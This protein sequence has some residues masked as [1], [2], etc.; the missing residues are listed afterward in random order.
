[1]HL[2][3]VLALVSAL[4]GLLVGLTGVGGGAL[5]TPVLVMVFGV[6]PSAA[7]A[8]DLVAAL[9]MKPAGVL[10][11]WRRGGV[12]LPLVRYLCYGS[13]PGALAGTWCAHLVVHTTHG[14]HLLRLTLGLALVTG[15]GSMLWRA[16]VG[17][18]DASGEVVTRRVATVVVGVV[19][20]FM[21]GL[22]SVGAGS[23]VV[24]LLMLLYPTLEN[25]QIA[26]T[27]LAQSIPLTASAALGAI[28]FSRVDWSL[29]ASILTGALP[30][31]VVGSWWSRVAPVRAW[32]LAIAWVVL[33]SGLRY[34]G[35]T[36]VSV[37]AFTALAILAWALVRRRRRVALVAEAIEDVVTLLPS[38]L[39]GDA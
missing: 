16:R 5:M 31:V 20:G 17:D 33:L 9:L 27:D 14:E 11:H 19:G 28:L 37:F 3:L 8:A 2:N 12:H 15:A 7:I 38:R 39:D 10:V 4:I 24:V 29:V 32:R 36:P 26:G 18:V 6:T 34:V 30:A 13:L 21:V 1:M 23:L 25:H 22:T 35:A